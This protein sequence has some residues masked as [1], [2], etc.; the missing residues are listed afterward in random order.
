MTPTTKLSP[1]PLRW[2]FRARPVLFGAMLVLVGLAVP[3]RSPG[4]LSLPNDPVDDLRRILS[5]KVSEFLLPGYKKEEERTEAERRALKARE[6]AIRDVEKRITS[7]GDRSRALLLLEWQPTDRLLR[8]E[9]RQNFVTQMKQVLNSNDPPRLIAAADVLGDFVA[10]LRKL[11]TGGSDTPSVRGFLEEPNPI[12][13]KMFELTKELTAMTEHPQPLV[14]AAGSVALAKVG[15]DPSDWG[16][17]LRRLLADPDEFVRRATARAAREQVDALMRGITSP[18]PVREIDLPQGR[19]PTM[20]MLHYTRADFRRLGQYILEDLVAQ[21]E[22]GLTD[23]D[24]A[25]RWNSASLTL[26]IAR[27]LRH[28]LTQDIPIDLETRQEESVLLADFINSRFRLTFDGN[29]LSL[30]RELTPVD[31]RQIETL[32]TVLLKDILEPNLGLIRAFRAASPQLAQVVL[33]QDQVVRLQAR[34][35]MEDLAAARTRGRFLLEIIS[36]KVKAAP[37]KPRRDV[38]KEV[39]LPLL[40]P[41]PA[42]EATQVALLAPNQD[43]ANQVPDAGKP[44]APKKAAGLSEAELAR[45]RAD[46]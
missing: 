42:L 32:Q 2:C 43:K 13:G 15:P 8:D 21:P 26:A 33:D 6:D 18:S 37:E 45:L 17:V 25:T 20:R 39:D 11:P 29:Q 28:L 12:S 31:V 16:P 7:L 9:M 5:T 30:G 4:Q 3:G 38:R 23:A 10:T 1:W 36:R 46:L 41:Q 34:L 40:L 27:G 19:K 24:A 35:T 22:T 44:E 14:R